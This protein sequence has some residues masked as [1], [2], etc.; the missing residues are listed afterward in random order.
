MYLFQTKISLHLKSILKTN[1]PCHSDIQ[2]QATEHKVE[3]FTPQQENVEI[4]LDSMFQK[5][6]RSPS[7]ALI[8]VPVFQ[9]PEFLNHAQTCACYACMTPACM[10]LACQISYLEASAYFRSKENEIARNY[11]EGG[12]KTFELAKEKLKKLFENYKIKKFNNTVID[13]AKE[14]AE[15]ELKTVE[16]EFLIELAFFELSRR[17]FSKSDDYVVAIHEILA[18][19]K[20]VDAYL[21]NDVSNLLV[22][23][24]NLRK[25]KVKK[26]T[27]LELDMEELKLS[28]RLLKTPETK[29]M[30]PITNIV[31]V[32]S[33]EEIHSKLKPL[34]LKLDMPDNEKENSKVEDDQETKGRLETKVRQSKFKVP[35]P[36][37]VVPKPVLEDVTPRPTRSKPKIVLTG[38]GQTETEIGTPKTDQKMVFF[39]PYETTP[40]QFFTPMTSMKTYSKKPN[41]IVKNLEN[42]FMTPKPNN[43][44]ILESIKKTAKSDKDLKSGDH[45]S[46][47]D[48]KD[49]NPFKSDSKSDDHDS[50][51][52][53]E[54][55]GR[56]TRSR[57]EKGTI[58]GLS[59]KRSIKRAT[60]PGKLVEEKPVSRT[61]RVK[62]PVTENK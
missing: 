35:V 14:M 56:S 28:P 50:K 30:P 37:P 24:A 44:S 39:T 40:D 3:R 34:K 54:D 15:N 17:E 57:V 11:F 43:D 4:M 51:P 13:I 2:T 23:S 9:T 49:C 18:E 29:T 42:D 10:L 12:L 26:E 61:R 58:K 27:G 36:L 32:V 31:K 55:S 47:S 53:K 33:K 5:T 21:K 48:D 46:K 19:F 45:C 8:K 7:V 1:E 62:Q 16:V 38:P 20:S 22:A 60:S 41:L 6:P 52:V 25:T 59:D